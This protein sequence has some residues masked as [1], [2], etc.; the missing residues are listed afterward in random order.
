MTTAN[1]VE[2]LTAFPDIQPISRPYALASLGRAAYTLFVTPAHEMLHRIM[3]DEHEDGPSQPLQLPVDET[4]RRVRDDVLPKF[5]SLQVPTL[6]NARLAHLGSVLIQ[7]C[8]HIPKHHKSVSVPYE[9]LSSLHTAMTDKSKEVG[10][11]NYADQLDVALNHTDGDMTESLWQLFMTSRLYAR[12]L[13]GKVIEGAPEYTQEEKVGLM[14]EWRG[15]IAACKESQPGLPQDP[16]G[17]VYYTWTHVLGKVAF[18][19]APAKEN[20]FTRGAVRAFEGGTNI[21]HNLVH[22]FSKQD[23][24]SDHV[25]AAAYGNAIGQTLVD[26]VR[27]QDKL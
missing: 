3:E 18:S 14:T 4:V 8:D 23:V 11:L 17:D 6:D 22:K 27:A 13:D 1:A 25:A 10:P 24:K 7:F 5:E 2:R 26:A 19:L 20:I 16:S 9:N 12:W 15:A 21:M